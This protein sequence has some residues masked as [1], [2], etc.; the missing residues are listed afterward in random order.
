VPQPTV[1][2]LIYVCV[3][4][5]IGQ[6]WCGCV[7]VCVDCNVEVIVYDQLHASAVYLVAVLI[8]VAYEIQKH[9]VGIEK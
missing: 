2:P 1:P 3:H 7:C 8:A 5:C 6:G 9:F 4:L